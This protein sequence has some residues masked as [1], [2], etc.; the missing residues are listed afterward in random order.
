M[1]RFDFSYLA[2]VTLTSAVA[3]AACGGDDDGDTGSGGSGGSGATATGGTGGSTG[4]S[5]GSGGSSTMDPDTCIASGMYWD[6]AAC[7]DQA[8]AVAACQARASEARPGTTVND[9]SCGAG[10][11]CTNCTQEMLDCG[12]D[13]EQY[14]QVIL[15]CAN[16]AGC[17][18]VACYAP[19]TCQQ[20][21][22]DA[23]GGGLSSF[24][25]AL[26]S[27]ISDCA[28]ASGCSASCE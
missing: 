14:C 16:E 12:A 13:P 11:T 15:T 7:I 24:S 10:C 21:I 20:V 26:A 17:T 23:P 27:A 2:L 3:L 1:A 5:G 6:G 4:G 28:E 22:D 9:P 18:G 19:T 8:A 25:L